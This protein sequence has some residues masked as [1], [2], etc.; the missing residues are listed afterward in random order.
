M[1]RLICI[2]DMV[3]L[4]GDWDGQA[5]PAVRLT[6]Q[7]PQS[8]DINARRGIVANGVTGK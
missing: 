3:P 2:L 1:R 7:A 8:D 4:A 6:S 5:Q